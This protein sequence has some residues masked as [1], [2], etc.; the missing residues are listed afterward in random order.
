[1]HGRSVSQALEE[2]E[3]EHGLD[4]G[5]TREVEHRSKDGRKAKADDKDTLLTKLV[6]QIA[7]KQYH[8][9]ELHQ[10]TQH[11]EDTKA[12][13]VCLIGARNNQTKG[14]ENRISHT[15][16]CASIDKSK[17]IQEL[18]QSLGI[19]IILK[20]VVHGTSPHSKCG[21]EEERQD[22]HRTP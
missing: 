10:S 15:L 1:M 7:R 13:H 20:V 9:K 18:I 21:E 3:Q 19:D 4:I 11:I 12:H 17:P 2:V 8:A 14:I 16:A 6:G 5:L 22:K